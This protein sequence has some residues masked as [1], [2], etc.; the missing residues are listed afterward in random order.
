MGRYAVAMSRT[1]PEE[2]T[3]GTARPSLRRGYLLAV[4]ILLGSLLMVWMYARTAGEREQRAAQAAFES[5]SD[6]VLTLLRQRL[7]HYELALRGGVSLYW[8]VSRPTERQWR[9]Y[10][11][12]LDIE[13]QFEG[14]LG[15]GY[16]P[17]LRRTDLEAL[18]LAMRDEGKGLFQI[19]PH[20][21][22]EIYG[23]ILML[24]PQSIGNRSALGFDMFSHPVRREAMA[25]ARDTGQVRL[26]AP[27][28]LI[29]RGGD[30]RR[31][32]LLMYAPIYANGIQPANLQA[33]RTAMS[34]WVY[35]PFHVRTF[36]ES[37][38]RQLDSGQLLRI[39]D[40]GQGGPGI[41]VYVDPEFRADP[42]P[43]T[44]RHSETVEL[45]GRTWRVDFQSALRT[46]GAAGAGADL[47]TSVAA[48]LIVSFLLFAVVL[49]LAHTQSRAERL[50]EAMSES[51]RRSEQRFR[52]AMLYSAGGIALLDRQG[53]IVEANPALARIL[54]VAPASLPGTVLDSRFVDPGTGVAQGDSYSTATC[55][56]LRSDGD[57][58]LVEL[59]R[60]P[61]PGDVGS[62]VASLVQVEDVTDRV[63]AE[64]EVRLLNRTLE[65]R[66][67]QRTR[68]LTLA[69]HELESFAY[70]VSHDLRAPL[71]TVEGFSRLLGERFGDAIG[72][73][74]QDYL[75][76]VRKA[77]NRM[78]ALIDALLKM[79]R[80]TREPL[81]RTQVDLSR[82]AG[83]VL[84]ELRQG[85]P[86]RTVEAVVEP[87]LEACGDPALLRNL[88]QNLLGNAWKFTAGRADA[89][90]EFG[91]DPDAPPAPGMLAL[92][93]RDNGAG[94]EPAYASKLFR[95][96]QR[97][98]GADKFEGHGIGLATVKRI[99][100]RHGGGI[101]AEAAVGE[102]ATFR[103][104]LPERA[105]EPPHEPH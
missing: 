101:S 37:A 86:G 17:Y 90:I 45:Y 4:V 14:L 99:V 22:R 27:V 67:E 8:S 88:L 7:L 24:E 56:L 51:Y 82:L 80:I 33:R 55:K 94:F 78:D 11:G 28:E 68:E 46:A 21:V 93:V 40:L 104:T 23:P 16:V 59:V 105:P 73:D 61:V 15:L 25:A 98:H 6:E 29:Q 87:G 54:G 102:G 77:A 96:F 91:R 52:N 50:A 70:S 18:Q 3:P 57:I 63:R 10:V 66:V 41:E 71:R 5:Q 60:S 97:L 83:E 32:G 36:M 89:R 64:R 19:R 62:D 31:N 65:A 84:A 72:P 92:R 100:E 75:A 95:P 2:G 85:E 34:G 42:E 76:R 43:E 79:S 53:R 81:Q 30:G 44:L 1:P 39:V 47:R 26:S 103:F 69:N 38:L 48:G 74:G 20:G 49:T 13:H 58:R 35:A 12:G 9:D